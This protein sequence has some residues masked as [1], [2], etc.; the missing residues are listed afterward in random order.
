MFGE[1]SGD[2]S[3]WCCLQANAM[4]EFEL[5]GTGEDK[6]NPLLLE[7][8]KACAAVIDALGYKACCSWPLSP[9]LGLQ[10]EQI[11]PQ[12]QHCKPLW[13]NKCPSPSDPSDPW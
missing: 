7:R 11:S 6:P 2:V 9:V 4:R 5:L 13:L 1:P 8:L 10:S 3:S 12:N